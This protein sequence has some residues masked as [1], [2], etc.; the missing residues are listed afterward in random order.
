VIAATP[1][2]AVPVSPT[3]GLRAAS[4]LNEITVDGDRAASL[5][6]AGVRALRR[7]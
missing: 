2:P 3:H 6:V 7:G 5:A 1:I 4:P